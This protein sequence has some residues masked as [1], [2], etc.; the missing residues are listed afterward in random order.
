MGNGY[1][2][3]ANPDF[4]KVDGV[5]VYKK[6]NYKANWQNDGWH[7]G[8]YTGQYSGGTTYVGKT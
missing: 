3:S 4:E 2:F 7:G 6:T 5:W 1:D 8:T